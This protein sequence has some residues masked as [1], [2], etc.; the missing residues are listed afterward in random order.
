[1]DGAGTR[2]GTMT[3]TPVRVVRAMTD[4]QQ[5]S[6]RRDHG[7]RPLSAGSSLRHCEH[8]AGSTARA[9]TGFVIEHNWMDTATTARFRIPADATWIDFGVQGDWELTVD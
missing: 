8:G 7:P 9:P 2:R 5:K 4:H 3:C 1:M 6:R